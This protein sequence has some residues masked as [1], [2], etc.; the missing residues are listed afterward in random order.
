MITLYSSHAIF[1]FASSFPNVGKSS[2][3]NKVQV[4]Y[5]LGVYAGILPFIFKGLFNYFIINY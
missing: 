5:D 3:I 2:F 4:S 1:I